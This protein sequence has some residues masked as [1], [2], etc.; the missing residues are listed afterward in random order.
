M[1]D[2]CE[3]LCQAEANDMR[4]LIQLTR[5]LARFTVYLDSPEDE[6]LDTPV[7]VTERACIQS[8]P[9]KFRLMKIDLTQEQE[10]LFDL[11]N[12]S[13]KSDKA[14]VSTENIA[15]NHLTILL[16]FCSR[17]MKGNLRYLYIFC[18][19]DQLFLQHYQICVS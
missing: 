8:C 5:S 19:P 15:P 11:L 2:A 18:F 9:V 13:I 10:G 1:E 4:S 16:L 17:I 14:L 3:K 7:K 6:T 12:D